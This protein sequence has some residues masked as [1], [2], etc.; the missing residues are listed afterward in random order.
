[1]AKPSLRRVN[2]AG[3]KRHFQ[4]LWLILALA[5]VYFG[6]ARFGLLLAFDNASAT[7]IWPPTGIAL[8][9]VL[10]FGFRVSPGVFLG[11][12]LANLATTG[13]DSFWP[14]AGIAVGNTLEAIIGAWLVNRFAGGRLAFAR[15]QTIFRFIALA[16]VFSTTLSA[17]IGVACLQAGGHVAPGKFPSVWLTWWIGDLVSDIIIAPLLLIWCAPSRLR[18]SA[19]PSTEFLAL[20]ALVFVAG[21]VVFGGWILTR[22]SYAIEYLTIPPLLWA[23]WRFGLRGASAAALVLSVVAV[24]GTLQGHGPFAVNDRNQA[25]VLVGV[26][27][28]TFSLTA[29]V[30]ASVI[31]ERKIAEQAV[32]ESQSR[33]AG[34]VDS[35]MDAIITVDSRQ[36]IVLYN[37]AAEI[38]FG[39]SAAAM[40]GQPLNQLLPGRFHAGHDGHVRAFGETGVTSRRMG[41]LGAISG[42]RASGQ[43]FPIEASIS[44]VQVGG[45][46]YFTVILRDITERERME[47]ALREAQK[48]LQSHA[49]KL[50]LTVEERTAKLR[51]ALS[52]LEAFSYSVSHDLRA[53]LRVMRQYSEA[54]IEDYGGR[55]DEGGR[56]FLQRIAAAAERLDTLIRDLLAYNR[57]VR[58]DVHFAPVNLEKLVADIIEHYPELRPFRD[59]IEVRHPLAPV[60]GGET[61]LTQCLS[62]LLGNAVKFVKPGEPPSV[63]VRTEPHGTTVRIWVEDHGIG[64]DPRH[65]AKIFGIFE[66]LHTLREYDGTGIG[67]AITRKAVERMNG[68]VGFESTPGVGTR[69]WIELPAAA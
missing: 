51:E 40:M 55:I 56:E 64:I 15:T 59:R 63:T 4:T 31:T 21:E 53:P 3:M 12:L 10:F 25:L 57:V 67:L 44:Q 35:A 9:A 38:M 46:K 2:D 45:Q 68:T 41:A 13:L 6:A 27:M 69:F 42:Q 5:A 18:W 26:F 50:E 54:L 65:H 37:R 23:A 17:T 33:L 24:I 60:L 16:A 28:A 11:A 66:R 20:M 48:Q 19:S 8:V 36:R 61:F 7:P 22:E 49:Q 30:L 58:S 14:S 43:E 1:M 29:I 62:N 47:G 32:K 52:D 39:F 34:L